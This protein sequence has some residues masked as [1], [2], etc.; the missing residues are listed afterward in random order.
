[1]FSDQLGVHNNIWVNAD[2]AYRIKLET[3]KLALGLRAQ[4]LNR[5]SDYGD[6]TVVNNGDPL[7][8]AGQMVSKA[9]FDVGIGAYFS[10][11]TFYFGASLPHLIADALFISSQNNDA[12]NKQVRHL[13]VTAGTVFPISSQ[14]KLKPSFL[15]KAAPNSPIELDLNALFLA[16]DKVWF[17]LGYRTGDSFD[18]ILDV[19]ATDNFRVGYSYD[20]TVTKDFREYNAGS[21]EIVVGYDFIPENTKVLTPRYF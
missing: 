8:Q 1:L 10:S 12:F 5:S 15:L 16:I 13:F 18:F 14:L 4:V 3:G 9:T 11:K 19:K 21:H 20:L 2:Y 7:F 6:V 17:G